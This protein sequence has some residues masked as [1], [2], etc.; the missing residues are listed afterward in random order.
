MATESIRV[1]GVV[2]TTP[3]RVYQAWLNGAEHGS[4]T[5]AKATVDPVTGAFT[6]WDGYIRGQTIDAQPAKRIV[7][8]WRTTEFPDGAPDSR[9]EI[10]L[11]PDGD[12][13]TRVTFVH[14]EIPE[15]QGASYEQGWK[16]FYLDPMAAHFERHTGAGAVVA[17]AVEAVKAAPAKLASA[18]TAIKEVVEKAR[19]AA[20]KQA[21]RKPAAAKKKAAARKPAPK[22]KPATKKSAAKKVAARKV[23]AKKVA[24][25]KSA[26]KKS[27]AKK[28]AKKSAAKTSR[29]RRS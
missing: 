13:G 21:K 16:D 22:K 1:E 3:E 28:A 24:A 10:E 6:A 2:P 26:A 29:K 23:A 7:Q 18:A 19:A 5:G 9:L 12:G 17:R 11:A 14:T 27:A 4:M 25:K 20:R 8:S 15:G